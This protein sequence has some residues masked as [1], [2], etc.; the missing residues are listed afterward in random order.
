MSDEPTLDKLQHILEVASE[1]ARAAGAL[2]KEFLARK[3]EKASVTKV[4]KSDLVTKVDKE[5]QSVAER[6][7]LSSFPSFGMLGEESVP[8]GR[9]ARYGVW[10]HDFIL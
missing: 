9:H 4:N 6:I 8:A 2:M 5:C 7:L 10:N 1:A 3:E